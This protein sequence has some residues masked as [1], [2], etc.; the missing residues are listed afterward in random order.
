MVNIYV[1][2]LKNNFLWKLGNLFFVFLS[3]KL[4]GNC[5][6]KKL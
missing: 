3:I 5:D 6:D 2:I 4:F 1:V